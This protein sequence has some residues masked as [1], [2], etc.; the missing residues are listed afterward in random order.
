MDFQVV[1]YFL[2]FLCTASISLQ[3]MCQVETCQTC[4]KGSR[5]CSLCTNLLDSLMID[6][7]FPRDGGYNALTTITHIKPNCYSMLQLQAR[8]LCGHSP[9]TQT[10]WPLLLLLAPWKLHEFAPSGQVAK[11]ELEKSLKEREEVGTLRTLEQ[12]F[13]P[14]DTVRFSHGFLSIAEKPL[15]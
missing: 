6:A 11:V 3:P 5:G 1:D 7:K 15:V 14:L 9:Q 4:S 10:G 2:D 12:A 8:K 13:W